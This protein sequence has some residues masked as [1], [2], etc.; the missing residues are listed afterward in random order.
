[1]AGWTS[2]QNDAAEA[3]LAAL[4]EWA[5]AIGQDYP[6]TALKASTYAAEVADVLRN[7][8]TNAD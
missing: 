3:L 5:D 8:G 7:Q 2:R 4:D 1:M 6:N